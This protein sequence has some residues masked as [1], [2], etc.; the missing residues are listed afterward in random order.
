MAVPQHSTAAAA[1]TFTF[2]SLDGVRLGTATIDPSAALGK[3]LI[4][5]ARGCCADG[6]V[7]LLCGTAQVQD[8]IPVGDQQLQGTD[9]TVVVSAIDAAKLSSVVESV[10]AGEQLGTRWQIWENVHK[11]NWSRDQCLPHVTL[12]SGLQQ[13][14]FGSFFNQSLDHV[15]LPSGLQQ[16]TFGMAF[17]QSLDQVTLPSGLQQ[18]T[19]GRYFDQ[20][21]DHVTLPSGLQQLT[22][23]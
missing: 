11:L 1:V 8:D 19:F 21:L 22:F 9:L 5:A 3:E 23:G 6:I 14:T 2:G 4:V 7:T 20:S 13:L 17:N 16:L 12:P 10:L 15:T 18:L